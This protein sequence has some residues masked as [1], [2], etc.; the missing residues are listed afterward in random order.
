MSARQGLLGGAAILDLGEVS[1][2]VSPADW[3]VRAI[4]RSSPGLSRDQVE[5]W[6]LGKLDNALVALRQRHFGSVWHCAPTCGECGGVYELNLDPAEMGFGPEHAD[7]TQAIETHE[8]T[9]DGASYA[10]RPLIVHDLIAIER[11]SEPEHARTYLA[12]A[13]DVPDTALDEALESA[14]ELDPLTNIW[15]ATECPDCGAEQSVLFDPARFL[16]EEMAR[17]SDQVLS[18]VAEIALA[19]HWSED[20]I[21]AMPSERRRYYL[22]RIAQ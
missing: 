11:C 10:I 1:R 8:A 7:D 6:P 15:I 16:A 20:A 12:S 4:C 22:G 2:R 14:A 9:I 3:G 17:A 13:L 19:Y 18:E 21:L 5:A